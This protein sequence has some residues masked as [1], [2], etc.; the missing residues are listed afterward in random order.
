MYIPITCQAELES[1]IT[2]VEKN[3]KITSLR[4]FLTHPNDRPV[5]NA[6]TRSASVNTYKSHVSITSL[7]TVFTWRIWTKN[8][9]PCPA[10]PGHVLPL[11]TV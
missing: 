7:Y 1:A 3:E 9:N 5:L 6:Q 10:E 4:L 8:I 11:Q 2:L